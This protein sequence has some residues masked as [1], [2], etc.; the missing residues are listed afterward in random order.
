MEDKNFELLSKMYGEIMTLSKEVTSLKNEVGCLNNK[1][2]SIDNKITCLEGKVDSIDKNLVRFEHETSD[3][4]KA[5]F[6]GYVQNYELVKKLEIVAEDNGSNPK[7]IRLVR[8]N[9]KN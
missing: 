7:G 9:F 3:K 8:K 6:D 5:L 1:V 2:D 4:L